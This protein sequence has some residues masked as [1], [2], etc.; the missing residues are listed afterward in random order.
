MIIITVPILVGQWLFPDAVAMGGGIGAVS[1]GALALTL[2]W[3]YDWFPGN[4]LAGPR[5]RG[6]GV[7]LSVDNTLLAK[8]HLKIHR[9]FTVSHSSQHSA[10]QV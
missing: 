1:G 9:P 6:K 2:Q 3:R 5:D 8:R 10:I 4:S 7:K